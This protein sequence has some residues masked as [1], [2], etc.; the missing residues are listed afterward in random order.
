M[1]RWALDDRAVRLPTAGE[2]ASAAQLLVLDQ[3]TESFDEVRQDFMRL[4]AP[5]LGGSWA[6]ESVHVTSAIPKIRV[7]V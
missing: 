5:S 6:Q 3:L 4:P 2:P 1:N 7:T